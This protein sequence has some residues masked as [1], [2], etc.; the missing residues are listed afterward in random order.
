M[1]LAERIAFA[2]AV[3]VVALNFIP[4]AGET[5]QYER[6]RLAAEP[7]RLFTGHAVHV[8]L[9]HALLN[10]AAWLIVA[11]LFANDIGARQQAIVIGIACVL[12]SVGLAW[13]WPQIAWYRGL[14]GVVHALY[15][16]GAGRWL[17]D[18]IAAR[19]RSLAAAY[20]PLILFGAGWIKVL[21]EQPGD[22][23]PYADWLGAAVV[24]QA[25][26]IGAA[27][28]TVLGVA[29]A[30]TDALARSNRGGA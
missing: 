24:P 12:I 16:A 28:G 22:T 19:R 18:V 11:R 26:L 6:V 5:L 20:L 7:W 29:L 17:A 21:L 10:A 4:G 23:L 27:C 8:N 9:A 30:V 25:H 2:G 1:S 3:A 13:L 15:F 14:S